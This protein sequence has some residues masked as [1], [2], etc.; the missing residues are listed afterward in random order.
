MSSGSHLALVC[1]ATDPRSVICF[2]TEMRTGNCLGVWEVYVVCCL[3]CWW[4]VEWVELGV[5]FSVVLKKLLEVVLLSSPC[6][7]SWMVLLS[8]LAL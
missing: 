8:E 5:M 4:D 1:E 2:L 6:R 7:W 3:S